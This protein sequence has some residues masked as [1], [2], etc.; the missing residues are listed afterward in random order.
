VV[1]FSQLGL[2]YNTTPS[3]NMVL[4]RELSIITKSGFFLWSRISS[5]STDPTDTAL[6]SVPL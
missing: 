2:N 5:Q 1:L 3:K 4:K 6:F